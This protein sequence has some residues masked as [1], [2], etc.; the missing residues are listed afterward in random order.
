MLL[1]YSTFPLHNRNGFLKKYCAFIVIGSEACGN[2]LYYESGRF[3]NVV[4][5]NI[6]V[7]FLHLITF[8]LKIFEMDIFFPSESCLKIC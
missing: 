5:S 7:T 2:N 3:L 8:Y 1:F 6:F 4:F